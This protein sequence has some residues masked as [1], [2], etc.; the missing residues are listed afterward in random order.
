MAIRH[1]PAGPFGRLDKLFI[2]SVPRSPEWTQKSNHRLNYFET[3][4]DAT[5]FCTHVSYPLL[6]VGLRE[7]IRNP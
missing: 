5:H 2:D 7:P 1:G 3:P 6:K 4:A